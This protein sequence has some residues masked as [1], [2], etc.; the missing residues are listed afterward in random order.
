MS[1]KRR[2]HSIKLLI[3]PLCQQ[4]GT[5][6]EILYGM[7][8]PETFDFEKYAMGGCCISGDGCEIN[9]SERNCRWEALGSW[10]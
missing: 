5:L 2:R 1:T 3:C 9:S 4:I 6:R 8:D 7:P 10:V